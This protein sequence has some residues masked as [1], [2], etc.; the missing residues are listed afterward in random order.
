MDHEI[1]RRFNEY[2]ENKG[3]HQVTDMTLMTMDL[4]NQN[5]GLNHTCQEV[6]NIIENTYQLNSNQLGKLVDLSK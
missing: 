5:D 4:Q 6:L 1:V 3:H 2:K